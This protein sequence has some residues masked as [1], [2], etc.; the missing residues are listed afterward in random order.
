MDLTGLSLKELQQLENQLNEG[1]LFVKEKKVL[2]Y[3]SSFA[4]PSFVMKAKLGD[5]WLW[6]ITTSFTFA[7]ALTDGTIRAIKSTGNWSS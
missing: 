5:F 4:Y 2:L 3:F 1:L 6:E 7:G